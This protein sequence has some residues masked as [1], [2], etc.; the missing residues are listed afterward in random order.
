[1]TFRKTCSRVCRDALRAAQAAARR[2]AKLCARCSNPIASS[3]R[4]GYCS[5]ACAAADRRE[6]PARFYDLSRQY[7]LRAE[8]NVAQCQ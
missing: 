8:E 1:M 3:R 2:K 4:A 7:R 5:R 6:N